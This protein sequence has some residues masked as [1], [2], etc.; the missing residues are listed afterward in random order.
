MA[1]SGCVVGYILQEWGNGSQ[2]EGTICV[3]EPA[4]HPEATTGGEGCACKAVAVDVLR[5][6]GR[7]DQ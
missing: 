2:L 3:D 1:V 4:W 6:A 5:T 7:G